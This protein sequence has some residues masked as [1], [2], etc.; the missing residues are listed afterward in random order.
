[1]DERIEGRQH[2]R[3]KPNPRRLRRQ[4]PQHAH[5]SGATRHPVTR[6]A[7]RSPRDGEIEPGLPDTDPFQT[8]IRQ[9][10]RQVRIDEQHTE[11]CDRQEAEERLDEEDDGA[12][13]PPLR[14]VRAGIDAR[15]RMRRVPRE[16]ADH[17]RQPVSHEEIGGGKDAL[18]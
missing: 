1:M 7:L 17:F 10:W 5:M 14:L 2:A 3:A 12:V 9:P 13:R 6:P 11:R 8:Q 18:R 4:L 15:M 16:P